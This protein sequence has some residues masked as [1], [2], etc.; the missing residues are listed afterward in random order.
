MLFSMKWGIFFGSMVNYY[1]CYFF[2]SSKEPIYQHVITT[3]FHWDPYIR[4]LQMDASCDRR[5]EREVSTEDLV[6]DT[7]TENN[8]F[9]PP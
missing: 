9:G 2:V 5:K 1:G 4:T 6:S 7:K 8:A 3:R